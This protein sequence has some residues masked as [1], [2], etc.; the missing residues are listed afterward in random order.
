ME[1]AL[2][3]LERQPATA[4]TSHSIVTWVA[5]RTSS[6][7]RGE[8]PALQGAVRGAGAANSR[9]GCS[10]CLRRGGCLLRNPHA[11]FLPA[12]LIGSMDAHIHQSSPV[13]N[14]NWTS[15]PH[16]L[17]KSACHGTVVRI[18]RYSPH[19]GQY[20]RLP[21]I[22][23]ISPSHT[24]S[25]GSAQL[26]F[27]ICQ[28]RCATRALAEGLVDISVPVSMGVGENTVQYRT[29]SDYR[30]VIAGVSV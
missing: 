21:S 9:E 13:T 8:N 5:S 17:Q 1:L 24:P 10:P 7:L 19:C 12:L 3:P 14:A 4:S 25:A 6:F 16:W 22:S 28:L 20:S 15:S 18:S 2:I 26:H 11:E 27:L 30:T 29:V 23:V